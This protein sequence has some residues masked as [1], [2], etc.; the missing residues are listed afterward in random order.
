MADPHEEIDDEFAS[1]Y[2]HLMLACAGSVELP[3]KVK[4]GLKA[5]TISKTT[6][7]MTTDYSHL[8]FDAV[9]K[10]EPL[11]RISALMSAMS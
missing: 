1:V 7:D 9:M 10:V 8:S 5:G 11:L 3:E 2:A 6:H 4:D